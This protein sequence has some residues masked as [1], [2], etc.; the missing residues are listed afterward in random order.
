M[1][2]GFNFK[3]RSRFY[4]N[5]AMSYQTALQNSTPFTAEKFILLDQHG[6]EVLLLIVVSSFESQTPFQPLELAKDQSLIRLVDEYYGDPGTSSIRYESDVA[7][8]KLFVDVLVNAQA[9][10]PKGRPVEQLTV[11]VQVGDIRKVLIVQGDRR[12]TIG[13]FGKTP[14]KP[15]NFDCPTFYNFRISGS[16]V[17]DLL[18]NTF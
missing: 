9:Y 13:P 10:A 17:A 4:K 5:I 6:Q 11:E 3:A 18:S 12:W 16:S 8:E 1:G 15:E 2:I 14:S 7:L